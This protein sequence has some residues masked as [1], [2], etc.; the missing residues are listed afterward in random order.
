MKK[1]VIL[2]VLMLIYLS[3]NSQPVQP[4]RMCAE[5]EPVTGTLIR[6][7]LGIPY[8]LVR[9]L[10]EDD[11][12]YVLVEN[13]YQQ[14]E[15]MAAF[16]NEHV[17]IENCRFFHISTNSHWTRDWGPHSIFDGEGNWAIIDPIFDGYPWVPG[18]KRDYEED[19]DV[20]NY[21]AGYL[22][23]EVYNMP[24][25]LTG[26]NFMTDGMGKAF[27]TE[28]ML[29]ENLQI[30]S[31]DEFF[32]T[33]SDYTGINDY[34][35]LPNIESYGIQHIDCGAKL[36]AEETV[37]IKRLPSWHEDYERQEELAHQFAT[38]ENCFGRPYRIYRID[39]EPYWGNECAAYTNSYILNDKVLVPLFGIEADAAALETYEI[40]MPGYEVIGI[41]YS[42]WYYYDALHCRTREI[43]D[44]N[45]LRI[46]H[47]NLDYEHPE[48]EPAEIVCMID[49]RSESG[50][51]SEE[52]LL[53]WRI[54]GND[55]F[56]LI[57]LAEST[58]QDTFTAI[59][60][61]QPGET[62]IEYYISAAD[63]SGRYETLPRTAPA[64]LFTFKICETSADINSTH[65]DFDLKNYP[66]P[67]NP[68][69]NISFKLKE[70]GNT[71]LTIFN[72]KGE[73]VKTLLDKNL[74]AGKHN[75]VWQGVDENNKSVASGIY[76]YKLR[77][78]NRTEVTGRCL[79]L[80]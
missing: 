73:K 45:M 24:A 55:N 49:D 63:N 37:L 43:M 71:K 58:M 32:D 51:I 50:L 18:D 31:P 42:E 10:A 30:L 67:F 80:K 1:I 17:N 69:T 27:S 23:C 60:P 13:Q 34:Q 5:W 53:H 76:F 74:T 64:N 16:N 40:A 21:L 3:I 47:R 41:Y 57:Q 22:N 52:L 4:V 68:T 26:G 61:E 28:Q 65:A 39:C 46:V 36:L 78:N 33:V 75:V 70:S 11:S 77:L 19:D 25:Y 9:E 7:P 35:M 79:L 14:N 44:R 48:T 12:L 6:W 8:E 54:S 62:I 72:L 15:A 38:M 59:I 56:N 2:L 20:N 66:N 29:A